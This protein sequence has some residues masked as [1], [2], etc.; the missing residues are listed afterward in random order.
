[1]DKGIVKYQLASNQSFFFFANYESYLS[2]GVLSFCLFCF[3]EKGSHSVYQAA[4]CFLN[5]HHHVQ[6]ISFLFPILFPFFSFSSFFPPPFSYQQV[7]FLFLISKLQFF[8][9]FSCSWLS[10]FLRC[11]HFRYVN[12]LKSS[13]DA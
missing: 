13:V 4:L 5:V 10:H 11:S 9:F 8:T 1:M 3:L 2:L 6:E 7:L 12:S